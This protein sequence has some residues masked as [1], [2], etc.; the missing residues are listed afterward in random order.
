MNRYFKDWR[1]L[2]QEIGIKAIIDGL[3]GSIIFTLF[4]LVPTVLIYFQI[5][6]M[7][8]HRI[9]L[10]VLLL[11]LTI[12]GISAIQLYLWQKAI[13][14]RKPDLQVS[15][16]SLFIK[17]MIIHSIVIITIGLLFIFIWIPMLQV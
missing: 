3:F 17:Q 9:N 14:L 13:L 11:T 5:I 2:K 16:K 4:I 1:K 8:Y 6:S 7:Y 15:I 10:L 12:V